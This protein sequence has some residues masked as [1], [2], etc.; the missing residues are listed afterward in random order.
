MTCQLQGIEMEEQPY[1]DI[2]QSPLCYKV[3]MQV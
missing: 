2:H 3:I 1:F